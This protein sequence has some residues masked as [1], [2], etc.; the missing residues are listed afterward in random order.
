MIDD[1]DT[2]GEEGNRVTKGKKAPNL[3]TNKSETF[4]LSSLSSSSSEKRKKRRKQGEE[5]KNAQ[6][7]AYNESNRRHKT[8]DQAQK[9][10]AVDRFVPVGREHGQE[11]EQPVAAEKQAEKRGVQERGS[12]DMV[13][14]ALNVPT[15][16]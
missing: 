7:K 11:Q 14:S 8:D 12:K 16:I 2:N 9:Q 3:P 13:D 1:N 4:P 10:R 6:K 5:W 15:N